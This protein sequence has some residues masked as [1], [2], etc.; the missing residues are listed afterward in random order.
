M[1]KKPR[2]VDDDMEPPDDGPAPAASAPHI[3]GLEAAGSHS[4]AVRLSNGHRFTLLMTGGGSNAEN[5]ARLAELLA[6][7]AHTRC[8]AR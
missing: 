5:A 6:A 4:L 2:P 1:A 3:A 8:V 7:A